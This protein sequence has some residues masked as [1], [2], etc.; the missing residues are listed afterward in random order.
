MARLVRAIRMFS[1]VAPARRSHH[2]LMDGW[3]YIM[4][5]RRDGT[6]YVGVTSD[7]VQRVWQHREGLVEGF[8]KR[9]GLKRLVY[10]E[11]H[12]TIQAAIVRERRLKHWPRAWKI[13]LIQTGNPDWN[14][15]YASL[16]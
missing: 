13:H 14:D 9:Y 7:I 10:V 3:M 12:D 4:T 8:T 16:L 2:P 6:L 5:N 1:V 15:L 11:R